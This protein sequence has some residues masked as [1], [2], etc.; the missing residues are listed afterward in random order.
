MIYHPIMKII[1]TLEDYRHY[2]DLVMV[3]VEIMTD[4]DEVIVN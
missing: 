4:K 1:L 3:A 2:L